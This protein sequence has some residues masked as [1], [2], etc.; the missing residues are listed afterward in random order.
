MIK[1]LSLTIADLDIQKNEIAD[2]QGIKVTQ[3]RLQTTLWYLI[4]T[5]LDAGI[6]LLRKVMTTTD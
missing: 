1:K 5:E 2:K 6:K 4:T 3:Q